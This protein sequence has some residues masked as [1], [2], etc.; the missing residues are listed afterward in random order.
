MITSWFAF[1]FNAFLGVYIIIKNPR[2]FVHVLFASM[3]FILALWNI[4]TL[5]ISVLAVPLLQMGNVALVGFISYLILKYRVR[6]VKVKTE[7]YKKIPLANFLEKGWLFSIKEPGRILEIFTD[8]VTH[9]IQG[10]YITSEQPEKIRQKYKLD[11]ISIIQITKEVRSPYSIS[12]TQMDS[13]LYMIKEFLIYADDSVVGI[14]GLGFLIFYNG[15]H[16]VVKFLEDIEEIVIKRNSRFIF[17]I[18]PSFSEE[19]SFVKRYIR[20]LKEI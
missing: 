17:D 15:F 3:V 20:N 1:F 4:S 11:K 13:L 9:G 12:P 14:D 2:N 16:K 8:L 10:L 19:I 6:Y 5:F 18:D 7:D